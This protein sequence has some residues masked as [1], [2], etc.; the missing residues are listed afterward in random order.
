MNYSLFLTCLVTVVAWQSQA[1]SVLAADIDGPRAAVTSSA[2]LQSA[3]RALTAVQGAKG[4]DG[5]ATVLGHIVRIREAQPEISPREL[6]RGVIGQIRDEEGAELQAA[7]SGLMSSGQL[8]KIIEVATAPAAPAAPSAAAD[9][10]YI[11]YEEKKYLLDGTFMEQKSCRGGPG[12][13]YLPTLTDIVVKQVKANPK[14]TIDGKEQTMLGPQLFKVTSDASGR[15]SVLVR[16]RVYSRALT[17]ELFYNMYYVDA[18]KGILN[19]ITGSAAENRSWMMRTFPGQVADTMKDSVKA[20]TLLACQQS[21]RILEDAVTGARVIG[22]AVKW[23]GKRMVG[24][25]KQ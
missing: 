23:V 7:A 3:V 6:Q 19:V 10:A 13:K 8:K 1:A 9:N 5:L 12:E 17:E 4:A 22:G 16:Y 14:I 21:I 25:K 18:Q 24:S 2:E 20:A 11:E 15:G